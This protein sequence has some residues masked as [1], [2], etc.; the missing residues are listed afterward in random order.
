MQQ[1]LMARGNRLPFTDMHSH[2]TK[3]N[4]IAS[5]DV[6]T[7]QKKLLAEY[8]VFM[9]STVI[10]FSKQSAL[11]SKAFQDFKEDTYSSEEGMKL[12]MDAIDNYIPKKNTT[13]LFT[14]PRFTKGYSA[15]SLNQQYKKHQ[16][17]ACMAAGSIDPTTGKT[18]CEVSGRK[19]REFERGYAF[20]DSE[21]DNAWFHTLALDHKNGDRT[22]YSPGNL[23]T[24]C[25]TNN[26]V[27]TYDA[28]D[29]MN[30]YVNGKAILDHK[31]G[32]RRASGC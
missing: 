5:L 29:Y 4:E 13:K 26:G 24:R 7:E 12:Y 10:L 17:E 3:A 6:S 21:W 11:L 20:S 32:D 23:I 16:C 1:Q 8:V 18:L 19:G 2:S 15:G 14:G 9:C 31:H 25:P 27:K 22:D 28:K 30:T